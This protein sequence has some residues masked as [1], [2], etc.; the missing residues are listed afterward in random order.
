M[1]ATMAA[2]HDVPL[3]Y[4][5]GDQAAC[6]EAEALIPRIT[7]TAVKQ[8]VGRNRATGMHPS[9]AHEL[10]R[11]DAA[12]ALSQAKSKWPKPLKWRK[13]LTCQLTFYRSD[14]AD[15]L[16]GSHDVERVDARTLRWKTKDQLNLRF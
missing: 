11:R 12:A 13:P 3:I 10:I 1:W 4:L 9:K 15:S 14:M 7:T 6:E 16:A 8:G 2:H 5:A